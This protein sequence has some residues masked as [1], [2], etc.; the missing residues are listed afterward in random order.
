MSHPDFKHRQLGITLI[1]AMVGIVVG[2]LVGLAAAGTAQVFTASQRQGMGVGGA[3]MNSGT[4]MTVI[5]QDIGQAGLGFFGEG[6]YLCDKMNLS[7]GT[8]VLFD[9][10]SFTP[11]KA[12]RT[13]GTRFDQLD[14]VY[15]THI[16]GGTAVYSVGDSAGASVNLQSMLPT[17]VGDTVLLSAKVTTT[18]PLPTCTI[19]SVTQVI[20]ASATAPQQLVFAPAGQHNDNTINFVPAPNV[21]DQSSVA[22]LGTLVMRRFAVDGQKNLVM[23]DR[24]GGRTAVL[25]GNVVAFR[26]EYGTSAD[27][28][29]T[30]LSG[31]VSPS[32][33]GTP[34]T[35]NIARLRA[36]RIG[37]VTRSTQREKANQDGVCEASRVKPKLF[38]EEIDETDWQCFRYRVATAVVPLRNVA[39]GLPGSAVAIKGG[40]DL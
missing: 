38:G 4:A 40:R 20:N 23:T 30:S 14:L 39:I 27:V 8:N 6:R 25:A 2:L 29:M 5:R 12:S 28:G 9:N 24:L 13:A 36:I 35:A 10:A 33:F 34:T 32:D 31:W 26:V 3:A 22:L 21:P 37:L 16:A 17:Q 15:S 19:R 11:V 7:V 1:E 18:S